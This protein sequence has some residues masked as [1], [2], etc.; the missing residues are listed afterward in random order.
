[1]RRAPIVSVINIAPPA[2][3]SVLDSDLQRVYGRQLPL[4]TGVR[5]TAVFYM[6]TL[7]QIYIV[8]TSV[9]TINRREKEL[10]KKFGLL[11]ERIAGVQICNGRCRHL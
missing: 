10:R 9:T 7:S 2:R 8:G 3:A 6:A 11:P 4:L 5:G 1:M